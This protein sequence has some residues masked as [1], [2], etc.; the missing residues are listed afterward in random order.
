MSRGRGCSRN[1]DLDEQNEN[2]M[3]PAPISFAFSVLVV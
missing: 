2:D 1:S 3:S